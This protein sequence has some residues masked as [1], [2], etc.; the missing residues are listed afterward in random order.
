MRLIKPIP[1]I[2]A[3]ALAGCGTLRNGEPDWVRNPKSIY[4]ETR[5]L[6]A[7]GEGDTRQ[8]AENAAAANLARIFESHIESDER[9]VDTVNETDRRITRT[10]DLTTDINILSSQTLINIQH[11][12][13]WKDDDGRYHAVAYLNRRDTAVIY[14]DKVDELTTRIESLLDHAAQ[15]DNALERY[16]LLRTAL[17]IGLEN[18]RL[19]RQLK[20]IHPSTAAASNPPYSL[21]ELRKDAIDSGRKIRVNILISD[22]IDGR[23]TACLQELVTRY[24]F[25]AGTP[26][27]IEMTGRV[28]IS[29]T[30]VRTAGLAF[31][32]Y[33]LTVQVQDAQGNVLATL[34]EKGREAVGS[35]DRARERCLRTMENAVKI[36]G[37]QSLDAYFDGLVEHSN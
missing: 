37:T 2:F 19:L 1:F 33:A 32:N 14:R 13:A 22:D 20:V 10:T 3:I 16:A 21:S 17:S 28:S 8:D 36:K 26:G 4:P 35:P 30:G 6:V 18:D 11:A 27:D 23:M 25:V 9:L 31:F 12:E 29:D 34:N 15:T 24:G 5:Y 7:V